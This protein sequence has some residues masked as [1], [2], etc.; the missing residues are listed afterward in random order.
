MPPPLPPNS[1]TRSAATVTPGSEADDSRHSS[2]AHSSK[3]RFTSQGLS[4]GAARA[5]AAGSRY[6]EY[7]YLDIGGADDCSRTSSVIQKKDR[8]RVREGGDSDDDRGEVFKYPLRKVILNSIVQS[9][10]GLA[11]PHHLCLILYRNFRSPSPPSQPL[12]MPRF[13]NAFSDTQTVNTF[14]DSL[15]FLSSG[16]LA[17]FI[18][19]P[20]TNQFI[21][22]SSQNTTSAY[23]NTYG[24]HQNH[25]R[26]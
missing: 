19:C 16:F 9:L 13:A 3:P 18:R 20:I 8:K 2:V 6:D 10:N 11:N 15:H 22:N 21:P 7:N 23:R 14:I 1:H 12:R 25:A 4:P 5:K 24:P 17:T 26:F